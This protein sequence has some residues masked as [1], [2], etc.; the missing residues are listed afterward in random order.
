[1]NIH[2][3]EEK[4]KALCKNINEETFIY[5][6]LLSYGISKASVTRLQKGDFNSSKKNDEVLWKKKIFFK[7]DK[8][9]NL[10]SLIDDLKRENRILKY[11]P[12]FIMVTDFKNILVLDLKVGD[13]LDIPIKNLA[14]HFEFFL[15][16]V[17]ME[18]T[19]I[20]SENPA[21]IKAAEKLGKLY[22]ILV[23][24]NHP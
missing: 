7:V 18:K 10:L 3:I 19:R 12:M 15:P 6:F 22:D 17:G 9:S 24:E 13:T 1:M 14:K 4:I 8:D 2:H 16:L 23:E 11:K 21:D 20:Q 5:E